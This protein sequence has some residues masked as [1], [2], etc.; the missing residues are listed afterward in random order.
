[1][2]GGGFDLLGVGDIGRD[3]D[4]APS[5]PLDILLRA[6]ETVIAARQQ[7]NVGASF[8]EFAGDGPANAG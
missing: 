8:R 3:R 5:Q 1:M 2:P 6:L 7:P 4:G